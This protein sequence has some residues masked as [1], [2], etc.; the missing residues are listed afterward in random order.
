MH[1]KPLLLKSKKLKTTY[2]LWKWS[3]TP[4]C[5][6]RNNPKLQTLLKKLHSTL[7]HSRI[8][9]FYGF[10]FFKRLKDVKEQTFEDAIN[11]EINWIKERQC[12]YQLIDPTVKAREGCLK[13]LSRSLVIIFIILSK[14]C[15]TILRKILHIV[16]FVNKLLIIGG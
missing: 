10:Y 7:I 15:K 14:I 1:R 11:R 9:E 13:Q 4:I 16:N 5:I 12:H 6:F 2:L 3:G 8:P